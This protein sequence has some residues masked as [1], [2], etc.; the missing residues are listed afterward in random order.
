M[1]PRSQLYPFMG[2]LL[3][4]SSNPA[5]ITFASVSMNVEHRVLF[6][7]SACTGSSCSAGSPVVA[8]RFSCPK[9]CG[10]LVHR[11]GMELVSPALEGRFLTPGPPG[12]PL[13]CLFPVGR[14]FR[15]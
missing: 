15:S 3:K 10:T 14:M 12:K 2:G 13:L 7:P 4:V 8:L 9:T 1:E 11:P 6:F 5:Y